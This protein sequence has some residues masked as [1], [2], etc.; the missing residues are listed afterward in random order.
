MLA[1][2]APGYEM[3]KSETLQGLHLGLLVKKEISHCCTIEGTAVLRAGACNLLGN[4]GAI[5][6]TIN[7][8]GQNIQFVTCH[9][10]PHQTES[11][12]R[13]ETLLAIIDNLIDT[14][15]TTEAFIFGDLNYRID[16]TKKEY[17]KMLKEKGVIKL[18]HTEAEKDESVY[19]GYNPL[20]EKKKNND[21]V[22]GY[23]KMIK[24]DQ[25]MLQQVLKDQFLTFF[26]EEDIKFP[27]TYKMDPENP[28][29][30]LTRIPG[31]TDR[32]F[33]RKGRVRPKTYSCLYD[34][35]GSD[36]RPV[37]AS[38][39]LETEEALSIFPD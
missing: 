10:A 29:Y 6:I 37:V 2:A 27:P 11:D 14:D 19:S 35:Y 1:E 25:L 33:Y 5:A 16:M 17:F 3:I 23:S 22:M 24:K 26:Y 13:N 9:L 4:K 12:R 30:C 38:Y 20:A 34:V 31:W 18:G 7:L 36:H 15:L 39:E 28:Y 32:I 21:E 8:L